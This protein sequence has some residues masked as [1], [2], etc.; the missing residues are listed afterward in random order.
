MIKRSL[1]GLMVIIISLYSAAAQDQITLPLPDVG[2]VRGQPV[3]VETFD[4]YTTWESYSSPSGVELGVE[5]GVYR[6]YSMN[7][8][9][10]WGLNQSEHTDVIL[11]VEVTPMTINYQNGFGVVCR[12]DTS[13]NGDGYYFMITANGYFSIQ[14]GQ[15]DAMVPLVDWQPS[16]AIHVELDRNVLRAVCMG[17]HLALYINDELA[18]E[19]EDSTYRQGYTGLSVASGSGDVDA[20]FDNLVTYRASV[21]VAAKP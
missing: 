12:A 1:L 20:A 8:G 3:S 15:G 11:E 16:N 19:V 4:G 10:V 21:T 14:K 2:M 18:A 7:P 17:R 5:N 13:N 6:A 9:Y